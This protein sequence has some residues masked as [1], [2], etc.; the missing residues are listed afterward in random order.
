MNSQKNVGLALF[1]KILFLIRQ[2]FIKKYS[3]DLILILEKFC[4][5]KFAYK[6]FTYEKIKH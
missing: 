6:Q 4:R 5:F 1:V 2:H 3:C